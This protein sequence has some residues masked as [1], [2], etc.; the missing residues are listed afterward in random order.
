VTSDVLLSILRDFQTSSD[1][2]GL[3]ERTRADYA[4]IIGKIEKEFGDFPLAGIDKE[5]EKSR[6][7]FLEW[8][9]R[10]AKK[11]LR[12]ADYAWTVLSRILN[13]G[14]SRGKIRANPCKDFGSR[15]YTGSRRDKIW[16][17]D[18]EAAFLAKAPGHMHLPFLLAIWT[19][20]RQGDLLR[21]PWTAYNGKHIRLKQ[22]KTGVRLVIPVGAPLKRALDAAKATHGAGLRLS[23]Q[24]SS[25][26]QIS[27]RGRRMAFGRAGVR[28][29]PSPASK[30]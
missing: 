10:M 12:Q 13:W 5:P 20:Q 15:L 30:T 27:G 24:P 4:G 11:S 22:S 28:H 21:L 3:A 14:V 26:T 23:D 19:A 7:V 25:A 8:R 9:D 2:T 18:D 29:A 17:D 6:G 16:T 1:F